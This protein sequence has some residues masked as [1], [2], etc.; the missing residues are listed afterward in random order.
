MDMIGKFEEELFG[1]LVEQIK[2]INLVQVEF[3]LQS[4]VGVIEV[5]G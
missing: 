5:I 1:M 2:G 3:V 4:G